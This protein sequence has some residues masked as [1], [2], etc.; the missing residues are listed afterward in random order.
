MTRG[1]WF[2]ASLMATGRSSRQVTREMPTEDPARQ[3]LT[4]T[5][6]PRRSMRS[7][8]APASASHWRAVTSSQRPTSMPAAAR[9]VFVRCLSIEIAEEVTPHPTYRTP[10]ISKSP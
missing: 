8:Q 3:G 4:K 2:A 1:S 7:M 9:T 6:K 10:A 5:G